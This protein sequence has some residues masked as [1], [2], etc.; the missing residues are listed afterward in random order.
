MVDVCF[1]HTIA[2]G[3]E[4]P[5]SNITTTVPRNSDVGTAMAPRYSLCLMAVL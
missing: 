3:S 4:S 1:K 5:K 2:L